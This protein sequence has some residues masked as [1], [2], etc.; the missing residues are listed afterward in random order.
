MA[1]P[2]IFTAPAKTVSWLT[3]DYVLAWAHEIMGVD[4]FDLD[5]ACHPQSP[6]NATQKFFGDGPD[7]DGYLADWLSYGSTM[8]SNP[9]FG[10]RPPRDPVTKKPDP[11][12]MKIFHPCSHWIQKFDVSAQQGM[13]VFAVLPAATSNNWFHD[14]IAK[15]STAF[16]LLRKRIK[17][18]QPQA[19]GT[20]KTTD[21]PGQA[22][23]LVLWDHENPATI[24][25][26]GQVLDP[27]GLVVVPG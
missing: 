11:E 27:H 4:V 23:M 18:L 13:R 25:R 12:Y 15:R 16:C 26:F 14:F 22:H 2:K 19:D 17:F 8:F 20:P 6:V 3:P 5:P 21:H 24:E 9:P 10:E 7:D 1:A